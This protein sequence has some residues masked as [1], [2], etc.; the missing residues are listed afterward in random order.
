MDK[1]FEKIENKLIQ[2]NIK[3]EQLNVIQFY[4][5]KKIMSRDFNKD[6]YIQNIFLKELKEIKNDYGLNID[7]NKFKEISLYYIKTKLIENLSD[8]KTKNIFS[9]PVVT[10]DGKTYEKN[11]MNK[12]DTMSKIN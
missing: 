12:S 3:I 6:S 8:L 9:N 2:E 5:N 7:S 10:Q 1:D 4:A 11:N